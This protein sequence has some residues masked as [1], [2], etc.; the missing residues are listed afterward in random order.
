LGLV[1]P[2]V[3]SSGFRV[4]TMRIAVA[5]LLTTLAALSSSAT[6]GASSS[7]LR[8]ARAADTATAPTVNSSQHVTAIATTLPGAC[9]ASS[10]SPVAFASSTFEAFN[11]QCWSQ[12][13]SCVT[14]QSVCA[15]PCD[16]NIVQFASD[17]R[18]ATGIFC[19][20]QAY[21]HGSVG[22]GLAAFVARSAVCVPST[23]T[24]D[25][26]GAVQD[27]LRSQFCSGLASDADCHVVLTCDYGLSSGAV[28]GIVA[29]VIA[30]F[31]VIVAGGI[32]CQRCS[33]DD[34]DDEIDV[35]MAPSGIVVSPQRPRIPSFAIVNAPRLDAFRA[36]M[37]AWSD[38]DEGSVVDDNY[39]LNASRFHRH[40]DD[41]GL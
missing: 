41:D 3:R 17:C 4:A 10:S 12:F 26:A 15:A 33:D 27:S 21:S 30:G 35:E 13:Q 11:S 2:P 20:Y 18:S 39:I 14:N 31:C 9:I 32:F 29:G 6:H 38:S 23:C 25:D 40:G 22:L 19:N 8:L 1:S 16:T 7:S 24:Q 5:A 36:T 34:D 28:I 37:G